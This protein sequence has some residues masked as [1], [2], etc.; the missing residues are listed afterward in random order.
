MKSKEQN[1]IPE[2][3]LFET[4]ERL[5]TLQLTD[6]ATRPICDLSPCLSVDGDC[7]NKPS[8]LPGMY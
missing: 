2:F 4:E 5:E 3:Y 8:D 6:T 1:E 7:N